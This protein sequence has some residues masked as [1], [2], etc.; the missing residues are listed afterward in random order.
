M[1]SRGDKPGG[2]VGQPVGGRLGSDDAAAPGEAQVSGSDGAVPVLTRYGVDADDER[3]YRGETD[4]PEGLGLQRRIVRDVVAV[5]MAGEQL[6]D[7]MRTRPIGSSLPG[8]PC[9][10]SGH[11]RG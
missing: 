9:A 4:V 7:K 3:E 10:I 11:A 2:S 8:R 6:G 1:A 5:W